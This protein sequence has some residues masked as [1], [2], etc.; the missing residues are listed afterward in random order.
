MGRPVQVG[1]TLRI[2]AVADW[3]D[4]LVEH[5]GDRREIWLVTDR[6]GPRQRTPAYEDI[7]DEAVCHGWIDGMVRR[8]DGRSYLIRWTPRR[9]GGN[10]TEGNRERARRLA[11]AGRLTTAGV[12]ALP[13]DLRNEL[14]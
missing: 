13:D 6:K 1:E 2:E 10:W 12:A 4:W 5:H 3:H 7:L 14:S 9:R 8:R 11:A